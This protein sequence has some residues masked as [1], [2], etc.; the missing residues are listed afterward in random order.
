MRSNRWWLAAACT[1]AVLAGCTGPLPLARALRPREDRQ[2]QELLAA[3]EGSPKEAWLRYRA[4]AQGV[5]YEEEL[6][7]DQTLARGPNPFRTTDP[8]AVSFGAAMYA[9]YC[10]KCH[11]ENADGDGWMARRDHRPKS[12]RS[13]LTRLAVALSGGPPDDW[14]EAVRD[15][16]GPQVEYEQG[17][18]RAMP[19][20]GDKLAN[21]QIWM[22]LTYLASHE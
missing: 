14:F 1:W 7:R 10:M 16:K 9:E 13:P 8:Q 11:G 15:G 2:F 5:T 22:I 17:R 6:A 4:D 18:T 3:G 12:F 20:F 19:A 21:E